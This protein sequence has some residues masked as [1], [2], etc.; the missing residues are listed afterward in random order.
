MKNL[1]ES[2]PLPPVHYRPE[3][4]PCY[5]RQDDVGKWMK[6]DLT[7]VRSFVACQGYDTRHAEGT[8]EADQ[9][10][11][12][13]QE[14]Q[15]VAYA[16]PLAGYRAGLYWM[17]QNR[18]LVTESPRFIEPQAGE[19]PTLRALLDAM[20]GDDELGQRDCLMAWWKLAVA[21]VRSGRVQ[22][23]QMLTLAGPPGSGKSLTQQL[24]TET[25]GGR[26]AKPYLFMCG[27]TTFNAD[28][29]RAEHLVIDDEAEDITIEKRR[30]F[31]ASI[32]A[33]CV[34]PEQHCHG[35]NKDGLTLTPVWRLTCSVNDDPER[36]QEL[37]PLDDDVADKIIIL[38][39][40]AGGMPMRS[41]SPE[42]R[43]AYWA[44]LKAEL[45]AFLDY[46]D[47]WQIPEPMRVDRYGLRHFHHP[48][49]V[50]A[51]RHGTPQMRLFDLIDA[52]YFRHPS[53]LAG[54]C[55]RDPWDAEATEIERHLQRHDGPVARQA[56]QLLR[57][58]SNIGH[59][60]GR[61]FKSQP[62]EGGRL[63]RR[64]VNGNTRWTIQPPPLPAPPPRLHAGPRV[65]EEP[66]VCPC[67]PG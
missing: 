53:N 32:K 48:E 9:C 20:F 40:E 17:N 16:G 29:F 10:V 21:S 47:R 30:H 42:A 27:K 56:G 44:R 13:L 61:L 3:P 14:R 5:Y 12:K 64:L 23:S 67:P 39:V 37:P 19:W 43:A 50:E 25:L 7:S 52:D 31:A 63:S 35:K 6:V 18:V 66:P 11:L 49:I 4:S 22:A 41:D 36:L 33:F 46:L 57:H 2:L 51:L 45:P 59:Y 60:L 38:K 62:E 15:N 24:I 54:T 1:I 55:Q 65:E 8:T 58:H 26:S 34:N 28:L